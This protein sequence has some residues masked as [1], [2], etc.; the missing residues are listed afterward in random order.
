MLKGIVLKLFLLTTALCLFMVAIIFAVQT[1]FFKQFYVHQKV[2]DVKA[3]VQIFEQD[4][5]KTDGEPKAVA[6]LE[7]EFYRMHNTWIAALDEMGNLLY[8]ADFELEVRL[9]QGEGVPG[10]S[11]Q[12]LTIPLYTVANVEDFSADNPL[13]AFGG[14]WVQEGQSIAIEG[15]MMKGRLIPLRAARGISNLREENRLENTLLINKEYEVVPRFESPVQYH[16][17]YPSALVQG[18]IT[19]LT[20]PEGGGVSRYTNRLFLERVKAFQANLMYGD[21]ALNGEGE[22]MDFAENDVNYKLFVERIQDREG[23][24]SYIFAMTSLQPVSEAAAVM[25]NYYVYIVIAALLLAV[26]AS[27]YFSTRI[28][29]PLLRINRTTQKIA[30]LDFSEKL[31]VSSKDEV[32]QLSGSINELS[33]RLNSHILQLER[34]IEKEKQ[35]ER[36]RK[37]FIAGVSHELK[38]PL[39]VIQSCLAALKDGVASHKRDYYFAA[40]EEEVNHMIVLT[41]DMLE[42]AKYESGTYK[43]QQE[44]FEISQAIERVCGKLAPELAAKRLQLST[45]L[46]QAEVVANR[47]RIE[48]VLVNFLTNAIRYTPEGESILITADVEDDIVK[49]SVENRVA[50]IP[51]EQLEKVWDRFYRGEPSRNPASGGTGLGLAIAKKILELHGL[52]FGVTNT[53]DGV[54]FYFYLRKQA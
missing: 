2:S 45:R 24:P 29:R 15:L 54:V 53:A 3:D 4:Y 36:T 14:T 25:R 17:K 12:T 22:V 32:G 27:L 19:K 7:Q 30:R 51:D 11:G 43:M 6:E 38:T 5:M 35:L 16:E 33:E 26:L 49:V 28:A 21:F 52:P 42:L 50:H 23:K 41:A 9:E 39:S 31:P 47:H 34:D 8:S 37:E 20:L 10:L 40:M 46:A 18:T 13:Y 48:Q 44:P 1:V